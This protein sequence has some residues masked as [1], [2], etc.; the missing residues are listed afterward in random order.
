MAVLLKILSLCFMRTVGHSASLRG[1]D[2]CILTME[3]ARVRMMNWEL[4]SVFIFNV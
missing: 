2:D 3:K 4:Y 1:S